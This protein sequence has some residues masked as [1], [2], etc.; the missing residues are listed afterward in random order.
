MDLSLIEEGT[1]LIN[2]LLEM[3]T[4]VFWIVWD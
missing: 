4:E 2:S 3:K 1:Y